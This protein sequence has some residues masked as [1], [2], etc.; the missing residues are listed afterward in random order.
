MSEARAES[1][2]R[3]AEKRQLA[4]L[5]EFMTKT[6]IDYQLLFVADLAALPEQRLV[7]AMVQARRTHES[8]CAEFARRHKARAKAAEAGGPAEGP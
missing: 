8:L 1:A 7:E 4:E 6:G 3:E 2:D 5:A